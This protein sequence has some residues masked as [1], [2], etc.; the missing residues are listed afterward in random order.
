MLQ[1]TLDN[2]GQDGNWLLPTWVEEGN[3]VRQESQMPPDPIPLRFSDWSSLG[4]PRA[5]TIPHSASD[6]EE[7]NVNIPNQLNVQSGTVPRHETIRTNSPEEVIIPPPSNQQVEEQSVH[8][9]EVEPNPLNTEVRMQRDDMGTDRQNNVSIIQASGNVIPPIGVGEF[10][11]SPNVHPEPEN[12]TDTSRGSHV[13]TQEIGLQE[14]PVIPPVERLT[15]SRDRMIIPENMIIGQPYPCEGIYPQGTST[16]NRR[17]YPNDSS[18]DNR[19]Y[20]GRRYPNERG[21]PPDEGRYPNR[22]K[23]SKERRITR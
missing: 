17:N 5:R 14:I 22:Q 23:T 6:R 12:N 2:N 1:S 19:L 7:Q 3:D 15:S 4:S 16:S 18:A 8:A 20:K 21:R 10:T 11:P 9:I 13:R